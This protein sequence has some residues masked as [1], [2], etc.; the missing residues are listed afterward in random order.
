MPLNTLGLVAGI[1][2]A[3]REGVEQSQ[4]ARVALPGA[5]FPNLALGVIIV[6]Q[7]AKQEAASEAAQA[8][9]AAG[10]TVSPG[11]SGSRASGSK[12]GGIAGTVLPI[13]ASIP[14]PSY[15]TVVEIVRAATRKV[16]DTLQADTGSWQGLG[17]V[18][19]QFQWFRD[20]QELKGQNDPEY[21]IQAADDDHYLAVEVCY[22]GD[23]GE[24]VITRSPWIPVG[25][26]KREPPKP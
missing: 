6:D 8:L 9:A 15:P 24:A 25:D 13:P 18:A 16:G 5:I 1:A 4:V 11:A 23:G 14:Q 26:P 21:T 12:G 3:R 7:L 10:G 22:V 19:L 2:V 20:Q 17:S